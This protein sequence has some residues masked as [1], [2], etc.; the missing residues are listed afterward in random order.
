M[1]SVCGGLAKQGGEAKMNSNT[2]A[3]RGSGSRQTPGEQH[4]TSIDADRGVITDRD[5]RELTLV[6]VSDDV[7][8]PVLGYTESTIAWGSSPTR[9]VTHAGYVSIDV[10]SGVPAACYYPRLENVAEGAPFSVSLSARILDPEVAGYEG[11]PFVVRLLADEFVTARHGAALPPAFDLVYLSLADDLSADTATDEV[12]NDGGCEYR[13]ATDEEVREAVGAAE[14]EA[15]W[16]PEPVSLRDGEVPDVDSHAARNLAKIKQGLE[17]GLV[18]AEDL[19]SERRAQLGIDADDAD[20]PESG[21]ES[22]DS[23]LMTDGGQ[24]RGPC[25]ALLNRIRRGS[26]SDNGPSEGLLGD[27]A[28]EARVY[29]SERR[30]QPFAD[31]GVAGDAD[32]ETDQEDGKNVNE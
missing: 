18:E 24:T 15:P 23:V 27:R 30:P 19:S 4:T 31:G 12:A 22:D 7:R 9:T 5:G 6:R 14:E 26:E 13:G 17:D 25:R 2:G 1:A 28:P 3:E 10:S 11:A 16:N 21:S 8:L 32:D 29:H 20:A